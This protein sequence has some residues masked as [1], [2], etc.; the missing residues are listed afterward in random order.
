MRRLDDE[1]FPNI[2]ISYLHMV[3]RRAL[4]FPCTKLLKWLIDH[5]NMQRCLINDENGKCVGIFLPV[6]VH[7][8]YKL[9]DPEE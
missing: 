2:R 3:A 1:V 8:Y 4:V 5:K 6:E 9:R 7:N